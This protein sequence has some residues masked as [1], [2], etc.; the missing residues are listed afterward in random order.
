[1]RVDSLQ[2]IKFEAK[3][4]FETLLSYNEGEDIIHQL[5]F[6]KKEATIINS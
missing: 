1:M 2:D 3:N 4:Y 6:V 5:D